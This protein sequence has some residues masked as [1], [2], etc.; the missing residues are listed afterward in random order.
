VFEAVRRNADIWKF[1][2]STFNNFI[3]LD[4]RL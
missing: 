4:A 1:C 3:D 2:G